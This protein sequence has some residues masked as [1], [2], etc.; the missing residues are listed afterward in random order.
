MSSFGNVIL[1]TLFKCCEKTCGWKIVVE[2]HV[3]LFK[4][5]KMLFKQHN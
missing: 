4:Q 2:I 3:V 5:Q 1:V